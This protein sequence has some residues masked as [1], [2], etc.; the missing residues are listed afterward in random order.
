MRERE[1]RGERRRREMRRPDNYINKTASEY[2]RR[3][4]GYQK[5]SE[6]NTWRSRKREWKRR[7]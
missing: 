3:A 1:T 5:Y 4:R 6:N 2:I 7:N